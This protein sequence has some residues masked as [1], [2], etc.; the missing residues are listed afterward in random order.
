MKYKNEMLVDIL[1]ILVHKL[2]TNLFTK[3]YIKT[4]RKLTDPIF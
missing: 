3:T 2:R 1:N 4:R